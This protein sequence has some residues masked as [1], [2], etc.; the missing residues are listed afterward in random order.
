MLKQCLVKLGLQGLRDVS[1]PQQS[2]QFL[3]TSTLAPQLLPAALYPVSD[4]ATPY[5]IDSLTLTKPQW[6]IQHCITGTIRTH[7]H[8]QHHEQAAEVEFPVINVQCDTIDIDARTVVG[9][10]NVFG[11]CSTSE[12]NVGGLNL[13]ADIFPAGDLEGG[14]EARGGVGSEELCTPQGS[15]PTQ[16]EETSLM[17]NITWNF[18]SFASR[19]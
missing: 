5:E 6:D 17:A 13:V 3:S 14:Q 8:F 15:V 7:F 2:H 4:I 18:S 1:T 9:E 11:V 16:L 12:G 19:Y 10:G